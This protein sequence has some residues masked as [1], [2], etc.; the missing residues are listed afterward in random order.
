MAFAPSQFSYAN[1][2]SAFRVLTGEHSSQ[3]GTKFS[4]SEQSEARSR[5]PLLVTHRSRTLQGSDGALSMALGPFVTALEHVS[6]VSAEIVGKPARSFF[7]TVI[8]TFKEAEKSSSSG[9]GGGE[10]SSSGIAI[11]GDDVESDLGGGAAELG[12][13]RVLG[14]RFI[15]L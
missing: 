12:L 11:I 4:A 10:L 7:Q 9:R 1:L 5:A 6:G 15:D 8:G 13:W 2:D 14:M 3:Q